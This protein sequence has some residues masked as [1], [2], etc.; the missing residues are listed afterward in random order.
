MAA[1][2]CGRHRVE[3][4]RDRRAI[5]VVT[6]RRHRAGSHGM[7]K[8]G[9]ELLLAE[10]AAADLRPRRGARE[11]TAIEVTWPTGRTEPSPGHEPTNPSR[12]RKARASSPA[13]PCIG[14]L[15]HMRAGRQRSS[16]PRS[17]CVAYQFCPSA[18]ARRRRPA[19]AA[20]SRGRE[21][22]YRAN[23]IGVARLEQ[24]DFDAAAACL[25]ARRSGSRRT[26][27][28]ARLNLAHRALLR[29][30]TGCG[31]E[32]RRRPRAAAARHA[33]ASL[34]PRPDR[35][36]QDRP[37]DA[38]ARFTKVLELDPADAGHQG[39]PRPGL[40]AAAP[41][42]APRSR[43]CATALAAEPYNVTAA[44]GL[45]HGAHAL[46]RPARPDSDAP[47]PDAARSAYAAHLLAEYLEQGRYAEAIASTGAE[48]ELVDATPPAVTF[49]DATDAMRSPVSSERVTGRP[50]ASS[51]SISTATATWTSSTAA[52]GG[53]RLYEQ[54]RAASS[55]TSRAS[56]PR[57][58][59]GPA[60][61]RRVAG[62]YDNDGR[63]DLFVLRRRRGI[64]C[65]TSGRTARSRRDRAAAALPA[66]AVAGP[67]RRVRRRRSRRR[68]RSVPGR[69]SRRRRLARV[70]SAA[71]QQRQRHV[72]RH[73]RDAKVVGGAGAGVAVV[74]TDFDNRRDID[75][76]VVDRTRRPL[77]FQQHAR[78]HVPRRRGAERRP[79]REAARYTRRRRRRRQQGRLSPI[80]SSAAPTAPACF[81]LSDGHGRF[82]V[83]RGP[84]ASPARSRA[85]FLDYDNDGL[86]DLSSRA[87]GGLQ[88]LPQPRQP[89]DRRDRAGASRRAVRRAG[90]RSQAIASATST[91]TATP[92]SSC[93]RPPAALPRA[94]ATTAATASRRCACGWPARVS[95]RSGVGSKIEVRAGSLRQ[96]LETVGRVPPPRPADRCSASGDAPAADVVRVLWPS[97]IAAGGDA[98]GRRRRRRMRTRHAST[99]DRARSQAVVVSLPLH[100][101]RRAL[102]VRHRLHGR[103]RDG[104]L[105]RA[106][107]IAPRPI[108]TSTCASAATSCAPRDGRYELRVTNELE[109]AL[110]VDRAA[111]RRG[112]SSRRDVD[113]YPNEG[114]A[115]AA[116]PPFA[117]YDDAAAHA[118][119]ARASTITATTC[120]RPPRR[121]RSRVLRRLHADRSPRL[122][123]PHTLTLDLGAGRRP[124]RPAAD[125]LD[126]LRVLER[127]RRRHQ[128][129]TP[130]HAPSLQVQDATGTWR[131]RR[132]RH[133]HP[134]R[135]AADRRRRSARQAFAGAREVRIVT[136]MRIYWDQVLVDT[137]GGAAPTR[138]AGSIRRRRS[139]LARLLRRGH[140]GRPRAV[141]LRL[142]PRVADVA[143]EADAGTLHA[144]RRRPRAAPR[145]DD[146]FV[147]VAA[148]RR[149][150]AVVRRGARCRRCRQAGRG[151]SCSMRDGYS[152]EMDINSASPT[153]VGPL[154]FHAMTRYPYAGAE[155]YPR[156]AGAPRLPRALQHPRRRRDLPPLDTAGALTPGDPA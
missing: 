1:H 156:H 73:H 59:R 132:R 118:P 61:R 79:R 87:G 145:V 70:E 11:S 149:D 27:R 127:Q 46:G 33:A 96:R 69:R 155:H 153:R 19:T 58:H 56:R 71:A 6:R 131:D 60:S 45:A 38:I 106:R 75:L 66:F 88:V 81:A 89:L 43:C 52:A 151:R 24:F 34:P 103:R 16:P 142:R 101:E 68:P 49:A 47:V 32:P 31:R 17:S 26:S 94:G 95:N 137:S 109:E 22:A 123:R 2:S 110:F 3:P 134:G 41:V 57:G 136:N 44:Y 82:T 10:R 53:L 144:R 54:R 28:I 8:T 146:M 67:L 72:H 4:R 40:S 18:H 107:R 112:R 78:R 97:G 48:P 148:G 108:P 119:L 7:V 138:D 85:Q 23:N 114:L 104:L 98:A 93:A 50:A 35:R 37:E 14:A 42:R 115:R 84:P 122:R 99:V 154:P 55:R 152:K 63:P 80:S 124:R 113:V 111:A 30:R 117:L 20:A 100:L 125:G 62:D 15:E 150:R 105:G 147:V 133:R 13:R 135:P 140:A 29:R 128:A 92:T 120:C 139:A 90:A 91:A 116:A 65:C 25:P 36:A 102:R 121:A 64:A 143:V 77:L 51:L 130:L 21:A 5:K 9:L 12:S 74:P 76:L 129:R 126:R 141:R 39:Q 83:T 86:L